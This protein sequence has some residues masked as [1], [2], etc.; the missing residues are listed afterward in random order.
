[1]SQIIVSPVAGANSPCDASVRRAVTSETFTVLSSSSGNSGNLETALTSNTPVL[2][3]STTLNEFSEIVRKAFNF[4]TSALGSNIE[5][6]AVKLSLYIT[7]KTQGLGKDSYGVVSFTPV[8][9]GAVPA[10]AYQRFGS[11]L[12]SSLLTYDGITTNAYNDFILDANGIALINKTGVTSL[13]VRGEWDRSG[14]FG[15]TWASGANSDFVNQYAD[16][17]NPPKLT[18]DYIETIPTVTTAPESDIT[19]NSIQANGNITS[20][21]GST[22]TRRGFQYNTV[23]Y[24]DKEVY[25]DGSFSTGVF[26]LTI[27]GLTPN[28]T[29][30][31]RAFARNSGGTS[32]GSWEAFTTLPAT[33]NV[34]INGIDRTADILNQSITVDDILNDQQN[35][36]N[37]SLIDRS[38]NGIPDG[39]EEI[40]ITLDDGTKLFGGYTLRVKYRSKSKTG[41]LVADIQCV[42]YSRLLDSFLVHKTYL[43]MTDKEII[44]SIVE[45]Y[46]IGFG[47]TTNNVIEGVTIDQIGFNY[48]QPTQA[49]RRI[50]DLTG[51]NW[52]ID[53][54]KD[55]HYF[56]MTQNPA[57]FN[58]DDTSANYSDLSLSKDSSQ[59]KNRVY[60]RGGT[61]LSEFT[62]HEQRGDSK[63]RQ[64]LLPD[65]PHDISVL[66]NGVAKSIGVKNIDTSGFD[67]YVNFQEKY[68]EQDSGA[69]LLTPT[70]TVSTTYKY[71]IPILIAQDYEP[72]ILES[73]V[74]EFAIF[75]KSIT[76]TAAARDR[77]IAELT[78]YGQKMIAGSFKTFTPGFRSGQYM[79]INLAEHGINDDYIINRVTAR[80]FGGGLYEYTV[81]LVNAKTMGI[82]RFL[83]ELLESNKNLIELDDDEVVDE[84]LSISDNLIS[85]SLTDNLTIDSTG[86]YFTWCPDSLTSSPITRARWDLFQWG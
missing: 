84:L 24:P 52:Y 4:N 40:T 83:I 77:A 21:G 79:N 61:K 17:A 9:T 85:D 80:S 13:G 46:C 8:S 48:I 37:F 36:C 69:A 28:T 49:L 32:Y 14:S 62:T 31:Y 5:I 1:M 30:Y 67:F 20:I 34:T 35:T 81:N 53:Y 78:D 74:K 27:P 59:I 72:S 47:I 45:T 7:G 63:K 29:Y 11:Q 18:I 6:T 65:K 22:P 25:E 50:V 12:V 15:G 71:D 86:A 73:G 54:D 70:D 26:D 76:T 38:G 51:R 75:D 43:D 23:Q 42:D 39:D 82:I 33:Y 16:G 56:P 64:F 66:V 19:Y 58:I 10:S 68:I 55:I 2:K 41:A 60:V 57:P 44:E 3:A